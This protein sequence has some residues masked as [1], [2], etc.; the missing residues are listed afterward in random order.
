MATGTSNRT[1]LENTDQLLGL[2]IPPLPDLKYQQRVANTFL[3]AVAGRQAALESQREAE[4]QASSAWPE[5]RTAK[6]DMD[7]RVKLDMKPEEA[8]GVLLRTPKRPR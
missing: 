2:P 6:H 4:T 7:D 3:R 5:A 8:L 1:R